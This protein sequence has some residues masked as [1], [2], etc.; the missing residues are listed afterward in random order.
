[1]SNGEPETMS[2][3][4]RLRI[5]IAEDHPFVRKQVRMMLERSPQFEVIAEAQDGAQAVEYAMQL[6]PDVVIL[7]LSMPVLNGIDAARE[8]KARIPESSIVIL[9]SHADKHFVNLAKQH[10]ACAYISKA[11]A[12]DGLAKAVEAAVLGEEFVLVD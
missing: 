9:S 10:G 8:I 2:M 5:L 4:Q 1:M 6:K 3:H 7:N 12:G 11:K